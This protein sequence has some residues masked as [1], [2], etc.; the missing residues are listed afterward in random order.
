MQLVTVCMNQYA[1]WKVNKIALGAVR[2]L[3][4]ILSSHVLGKGMKVQTA[5]SLI[6]LPCFF[7]ESK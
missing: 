1:Q 7:K 3:D 5:V 2:F 6:N 4:C